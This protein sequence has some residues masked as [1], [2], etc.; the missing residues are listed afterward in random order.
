MAKWLFLNL[1]KFFCYDWLVFCYVYDT[2][3]EN[4]KIISIKFC[5]HVLHLKTLTIIFRYY[6]PKSV[7]IHNTICN[8]MCEYIR[9]KNTSL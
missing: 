4:K 8:I 3:L 2:C 1:F 9:K 5:Q 7:Y 6:M